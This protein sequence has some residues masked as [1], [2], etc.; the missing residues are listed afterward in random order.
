MLEEIIQR[1]RAYYCQECGICTGSCPVSRHS[2]Q[3]SPRLFVEKLLL[4]VDE[5]LLADRDVWSCLTCGTCTARCPSTVDYNEFTRQIR[6]AARVDGNEGVATHAGT[7][8]ALM[9]LEIARA[10]ERDLSWISPDVSVARRGKVLF[11]AGCLP[12]FGVIFSDIGVN[13]V[14]MANS[15]I[16]LLNACSVRPVVSR[17]EVCCGHDLYWSGDLAA[18]KTLARRNLR[19]IEETGAKT[20][21]FACPECYATFKLLYAEHI[22]RLKFDVVHISEFLVPY[23]K[24]GRIAFGGKALRVTYQDPCRLGRFLDVFD[25]PREVLSAVPDLE[26]VEMPRSRADA[27]CC[28]SSAWTSCTRVNKSIQLERLKEALDTGATTL[29]TGC[30]KCNIHLACAAKDGDLD[31]E[32]KITYLTDFVSEALLS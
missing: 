23:V 6:A 17:H 15:A 18:F 21:V 9:E 3:Y 12:Y 2:P 22:G 29:V 32:I 25:A 20:V 1:T 14:A 31:R 26:L 30:P 11:F 28:G 5:G 16:R 7:L 10:S 24:S 13:P 4:G 8:R 27:V 19:A